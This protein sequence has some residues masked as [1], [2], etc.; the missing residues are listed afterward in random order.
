MYVESMGRTLLNLFKSY[1]AQLLKQ[2]LVIATKG[3][4]IAV[5]EATLKNMFTQK[6]AFPFAVV[7]LNSDTRNAACCLGVLIS[8]VERNFMRSLDPHRCFGLVILLSTNLL[9][10]L[11]QVDMSKRNDTFALGDRDKILEQVRCHVFLNLFHVSMFCPETPN[12]FDHI[13]GDSCNL[14]C[15]NHL[16]QLTIPRTP[17]SMLSAQ[18]EWEPILVHVAQA[19]NQRFPYE[20]LLRSVLKHLVDASSNEFLFLIDFFKT[21]PKDTFNRYVPSRAS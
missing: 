15:C 3:D 5:E 20:V 7:P 10:G 4:L 2:D 6:V 19:E 1:Y 21:Q 11:L 12:R 16:I 13:L 18:I 14:R 17:P 8:R 9:A